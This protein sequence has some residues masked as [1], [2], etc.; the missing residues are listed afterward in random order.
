MNN[1]EESGKIIDFEEGKRKIKAARQNKWI[2]DCVDKFIEN[3]P[4]LVERRRQ[5]AARMGEY[6]PTLEEI[7]EVVEEDNG[8]K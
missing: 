8:K 3:L 2:E 4:E 5:E 1:K 6:Y 7:I